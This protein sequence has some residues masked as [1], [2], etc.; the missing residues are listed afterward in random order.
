MTTYFKVLAS[1]LLL[2]LAAPAAAA[3]PSQ[4]VEDGYEL[5]LRYRSLPAAA[6]A[7]MRAVSSAV[8]LGGDA[9]PMLQAAAGELKRGVAQMSGREPALTQEL[10]DG[11]LVLATPARLPAITALSL[12]LAGLGQE[13]YL[14]RSVRLEGH[15]VTL[16][17]ANSE[18]GLLYGSFAWLRAAQTGADLAHLDQRSAPRIQWRMLNHWDNPDRSVER[19]YAG[20]SIWDWRLLPD[21]Q[22][23]RYVDYARANASLGIN[24]TVLN[25]VNAKA[26]VLTAPWLRKVAALADVM[27]PYGIR[28]FLSVR[29]S[30]PRELAGLPKSDPLD[31]R[32]RAWW[33][34]KADEIYRLIPDFGGFL[35]KAN[36]EGEPGP[37]DYGRSHM[38]GANMLAEALAPHQGLVIWRA[39]VYSEIDPSDRAKQAYSEF[40]P[41]DGK[42]APN[43]VL[44]VKN[45]AIDFQPREPFHPLFGAMPHT[46]LGIEFQITKEYLGFATHLAYLGPLFEETLRSDTRAAPGATV[47]RVIDGNLSHDGRPTLMAGVSNIGS[48]R[49]WSGSHFNQANWYAFGRM[50]W[51]PELS[52][53]GLAREWIAQTF[54]RE[55]R[56]IEAI[57]PI[58]M[59]S[60][61]AVVDYM[62][63]LGLHHLMAT[64]HHYGP[65]PWVSDLARPEWNPTYYHKADAQGIGFDRSASGSHAVS[66]YAPELAMRWGDVK[67]T[68]LELLLW[69]HHMSWDARLPTGRTVWEELVHRYDRGVQQVVE[70]RRQ[71]AALAPDIDPRRHAEVASYLAIQEREARWWRDACIAYFQSVNHHALPPGVV[72]PALTLE[73][74]RAMHFSF[75]PGHGG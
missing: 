27:R 19:G 68:P 57:L 64:S 36:S 53:E 26:E 9:S 44:Q 28:V 45:G 41:G 6:Q 50:A 7:Q 4:A 11:A 69:F 25:N 66:Q 33:K 49:N 17:A 67:T 34:A 65:G 3:A 46:N 5:W 22:D 13:G 71:W 10:R 52:A 31:L 15:P 58:M 14:L 35:V 16:I 73:Q 60:R 72:A 48:D 40:V 74:Y 62:T 23:Q 2:A 8:F 39:F 75:A 30:A 54:S 37:Q 29:F 56:V 63:P 24:A 18:R 47:A 21:A 59:G 20:L 1:L 42:F 55:P 70:M 12:P 38:D 51:D 32:V 43:V 61:E